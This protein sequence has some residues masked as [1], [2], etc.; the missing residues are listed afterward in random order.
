MGKEL[1]EFLRSKKVFNPE[2]EIKEF[3][4]EVELEKG[5]S[6]TITERVEIVG[7]TSNLTKRPGYLK[8]VF[9]NLTYEG[10]VFIARMLD[11]LRF[12]ELVAGFVA[13]ILNT[14]KP[15]RI[16]TLAGSCVTRNGVTSLA[17]MEEEQG[18][19]VYLDKYECRVVASV[20]GKILNQCEFP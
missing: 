20:L 4:T 12:H 15:V 13:N 16:G 14:K 17:I 19:T 7:S 11:A 6:V 2:R 8:P 5:L 9:E 1:R 10:Q 18:W 3:I